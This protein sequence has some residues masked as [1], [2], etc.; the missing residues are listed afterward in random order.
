M[1]ILSVY[2]LDAQRSIRRRPRRR[3]CSRILFSNLVRFFTVLQKEDGCNKMTC[4]RCST[5][6]CWLC[7]AHLN[8]RCPYLH[9]SDPS[10]KCNLFQGLERD[11]D[12]RGHEDY[13]DRDFLGYDYSDDSDDWYPD[14]DWMKEWDL[15]LKYW[16]R[17]ML[18]YLGAWSLSWVVEILV[19]KLPVSRDPGSF[20]NWKCCSF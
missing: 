5:Y 18:V 2:W 20:S 1:S 7:L 13:D 11:E 8:P 4:G 9:F 15:F 19:Q 16:I 6:F 14:C 10:S 12:D 3:S 17:T